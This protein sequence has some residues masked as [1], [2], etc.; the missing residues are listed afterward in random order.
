M[1]YMIVFVLSALTFL[2]S[3]AAAAP[4]AFSTATSNQDGFVEHSA[5]GHSLVQRDDP[6]QV[7]DLLTELPVVGPTLNDLLHGTS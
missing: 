1:Q 5:A 3:N 4:T 2:S 6:I 7:D